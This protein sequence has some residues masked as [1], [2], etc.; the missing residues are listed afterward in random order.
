MA[1]KK[2]RSNIG[3]C[4][5]VIGPCLNGL[6]AEHFIHVRLEFLKDSKILDV[7]MS[8]VC[9][10]QKGYEITSWKVL[11]HNPIL[12][13]FDV[14]HSDSTSKVATEPFVPTTP[15]RPTENEQRYSSTIQSL[16]RRLN[17]ALGYE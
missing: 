11:S 9:T 5:C 4:M 13:Q 14:F 2:T 8:G 12:F 6:N 1:D 10:V 3:P 17:I 7:S 15:I 16:N